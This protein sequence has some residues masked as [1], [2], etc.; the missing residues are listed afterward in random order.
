MRRYLL[1]GLLVLLS[2]VGAS[3]RDKVGLNGT[4]EF[5]MDPKNV[6]KTEQWYASGTAYDMTMAVPG[7][8]NANG[9]GEESNNLF[10]DFP[11]R[12]WYHRKVSIPETWNGKG[13]WLKFGGVYRY[14][15]V[16][17]NGQFAG[18]H[19]AYPT[20]FKFDITKFIGDDLSA[21]IVVRVNARQDEAIDPLR[22]CFDIMDVGGV[23]WGG[24]YRGVEMEATASSWIDGVFAIPHINTST[25]DLRVETAGEQAQ[26]MV[27][28]DVLDKNGRKIGGSKAQI[29]KNAVIT[30]RIPNVKLWSP[31]QPYLYTVRVTLFQGEAEIDAVSDRFGMREIGT[32]GKNFLLNGKPILL[33][34]YGD[35]CIFPNTVA[36]PADKQEYYR[37]FKIAKS[38]GF[39]YV[40]HHS[41][42]PLAE[43][44]DVADEMGIML[45]PEFPIAYDNSYDAGT[46]EKR[47][48]YLD[49]WREI[50]KANWNHPSIVTWCMGNE[51]ASHPELSPEIYRML[52][53]MD[54]TRLV[55]DSDGTEFPAPGAKIRKS[56]DFQSCGFDEG[57][58]FGLNDNKYLHNLKPTKP[59]VVHEMGNFATLPSLSQIS[60]FENGIRPYW[61]Y[62]LRDLV[63]KGGLQDEYPAWVANSNKLQ[64]AVLKTNIEAARRSPDISG[65]HQWL[66][67]DYWNG[68][69]GVVD[70]FYRPKNISA[71]E[72][73]KFNSPTVLLMD[74]PR[75]NFW[76]GETAKIK[77]LVSRYEDKPSENA[78]LKWELKS[79]GEVI[80]SGR[81]KGI[82]VKASGV[83]D[84]K[85][86]NV[87]MPKS[88]SAKKLTFAVELSDKNGKTT[89]DWNLWVYPKSR[90]TS[91]KQAVRI[92]GC[93]SVQALYPWIRRVDD[94]LS[95]C[96][97]LITSRLTPEYLDYLERGGRVLLLNADR[98]FYSV[99]SSYKPC[100]WLGDVGSDSNTGTVIDAAHPALS[101]MP[102]DGW[103]DLNFV[104]LLT[105]SRAMLLNDLPAKI[106]PIVRCLDVHETLRHKAYLFEVNVGQGKLLASSLNFQAA[107]LI[108]DP[109]AVFLLDRLIRYASGPGFSPVAH[110]AVEDIRKAMTV[111]QPE[112][113]PRVNGFAKIK[114]CTGD[115][116]FHRSYREILHRAWLVRQGDGKQRVEWLTAPVNIEKPGRVSLVWT[117][118]TGYISQPAGSF[119]LHLNGQ[120]LLDFNVTRNTARWRSADGKAELFFDAKAYNNQD[121]TGVMYLT[122][123][124]EMLEDGEPAKLAVTG[125]NSSSQ[126]WFMLF[127]YPDTV[128]YED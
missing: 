93:G 40:R 35:D 124:S 96:N 89:N 128:E 107:L 58:L 106:H 66:F 123:P 116:I 122:L 25:V 69:N 30:V 3:A 7:T 88:A 60:L 108:K 26:F 6:G 36:P 83:Q 92:A 14:A 110:L 52:K 111:P 9:V 56:L 121:S 20:P 11:G 12:A 126:R 53:E 74:C 105:G 112:S 79:G 8:W 33:R 80:A 47:Q 44:F 84:I 78:V 90:M 5:R 95:G 50:I 113:A 125:S 23:A 19:I 99:V 24:M 76:A 75:R 55:I 81:E 27:V 34:G 114:A 104:D 82:H 46:P 62:T 64:A 18:N 109:A 72:F 42:T 86:L 102:N 41:W 48:L 1:V 57:R 2:A 68:S 31:K 10:H 118:G 73:R 117:A 45:Q 32:A 4:W 97:L 29:S 67:Q 120:P 37:R 21:D 22:G 98:D 94:D 15:D 38:Y 28:V 13:I 85:T 91:S 77:I 127:D 16:W 59:V 103:C 39:N 87:I 63:T 119:T 101:G 54:P 51:L 115:E 17:V 49:T 100:W 65:Y 70:M 43:Y 61:L 71:A